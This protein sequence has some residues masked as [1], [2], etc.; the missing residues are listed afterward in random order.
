MKKLYNCRTCSHPVD[1]FAKTCPKCGANTPV[2]IVNNILGIGS[3]VFLISVIVFHKQ[4][5]A[6]YH[7][8]FN[9]V[10]FH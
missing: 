3:I 1:L 6:L 10:F 5:F 7:K 8:Y 2:K 4:I 9:W